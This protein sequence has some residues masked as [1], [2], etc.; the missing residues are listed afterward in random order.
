M[1]PKKKPRCPLCLVVKGFDDLPIY[2]DC[3]DCI[4]YK[5][6]KLER[7]KKEKER[8]INEAK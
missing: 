3:E 2:E 6:K 4:I 8:E 1:E 5:D 7:I